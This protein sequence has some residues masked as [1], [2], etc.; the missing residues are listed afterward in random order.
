MSRTDRLLKILQLLRRYRR[1]VIAAVLAEELEV[2]ERTIYR[3]MAAMSASGIPVR[4]E[5]GI[6][7]VL[8]EGYDL[9]PLM[10]TI[11]ELEALM[12]GARFIERKADP[13]LAIA[14]KDAMAKIAAVI[15][16]TIRPFLLASGL[17]SPSFGHQPEPN[18]IDEKLIRQALREE[19]K[20]EI[21][22][23]DLKQNNSTRTLWPI[24]L[25]YFA[26]CNLLVAW[27]E[28]REDFR[29]F[30]TDRISALTLSTRRLP[31]KRLDL[32][33]QWQAQEYCRKK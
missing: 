26:D 8:D 12:L 13:E 22:Y 11:D 10:F 24:L 6:G 14:A 1:P 28:L 4:G 23:L 9:P 16:T 31:K 19:Q 27:C 2:T 32:L 25:S 15:P 33:K 7:Y 5:A 30:R 29:H 21:E 20:I 17:Y 18:K 3:D